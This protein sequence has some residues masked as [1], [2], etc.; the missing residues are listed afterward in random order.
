MLENA[1]VLGATF[2]AF[3]HDSV[4]SHRLQ[5]FILLLIVVIL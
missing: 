2:D 1:E 4:A 3:L 5:H